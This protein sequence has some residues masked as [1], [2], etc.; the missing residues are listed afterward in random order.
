MRLTRDATVNHL[1]NR[2]ATEMRLTR[3]ATVN[4][5]LNPR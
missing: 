1:L 3:D 5:L 2:D 4:H